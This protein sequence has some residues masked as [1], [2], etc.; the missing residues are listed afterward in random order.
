MA[1]AVSGRRHRSL[2]TIETSFPLPF[3]KDAMAIYQLDDLKPELH[4]TVWVADNAQ[5]I[6]NVTLG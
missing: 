5:V 1:A 4:D 3:I 2:P 6:G